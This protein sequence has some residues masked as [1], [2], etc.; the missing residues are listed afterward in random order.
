L[1]DI[2]NKPEEM[3]ILMQKDVAD[4][5]LW[6]WKNKSSVI[7]LMV[8]KK[9]NVAEL[10]FVWKENFIPSPKVE[11]SVLYFKLHNEYNNIDD[12]NFL[13]FIKKWFREPRKMLLKNLEKSWYDKSN[14]LD[15]FNNIKIE[16]NIRWEDL[17]IS[18]WCKLFLN[19][20]K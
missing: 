12:N 15:V 9:S 18:L 7:S 20:N 14:I 17:N 2:K 10:I 19:F 4:K 8:E 5:I 11:S 6:K 13:E 3:L 1:Y 16:K